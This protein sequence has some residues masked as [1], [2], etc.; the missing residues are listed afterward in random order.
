MSN[1]DSSYYYGYIPI[2]VLNLWDHAYFLDYKNDKSTYIDNFFKSI[3]F[4]RINN[5]HEKL[6]K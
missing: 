1:E 4:K 5:Y 6:V 3:D 2:M